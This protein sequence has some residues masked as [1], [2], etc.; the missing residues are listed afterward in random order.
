MSCDSISGVQSLGHKFRTTFWVLKYLVKSN[1]SKGNW[2]GPGGRNMLRQK[3]KELYT[4]SLHTWLVQLIISNLLQ[5]HI[6]KLSKYFWSTFWSVP[7]EEALDHTLWQTC[8][9]GGCGP[10]V[11]Q[12]TDW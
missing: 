2:R 8:F 11:R 1:W 7:K 9:G 12:T 5:H 4:L 10:V 3:M 6:S